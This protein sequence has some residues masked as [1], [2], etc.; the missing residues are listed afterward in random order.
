ME[1][2]AKTWHGE[3]WKSGGGGP[4][5][6]A[7]SYDPDLHLLYIGTGNGNAWSRDL[8]SPGGGDNLFLCSIVAVRADTGE[9]VWHYQEVPER[10]GTTTACSR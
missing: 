9:Y 4:A 3:W 6:D 8:R 1:T 2:A 5:W 10:G 7:F